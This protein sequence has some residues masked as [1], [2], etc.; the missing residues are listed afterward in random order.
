MKD[1]RN[2]PARRIAAAALLLAGCRETTPPLPAPGP[3]VDMVTIEI[4][5]VSTSGLALPGEARGDV[6]RALGYRDAAGENLV[7]FR[8]EAS[9]ADSDD[10]YVERVALSVSH[11]LAT[12][13]SGAG[14]YGE[15]W[16]TGETVDCEGLDFEADFL[17][18]ATR[19]EDLDGDGYA[20]IL[21]GYSTFCGGGLEPHDIRL[22]L[23][24]RERDYVLQGESLVQPPAGAPA[25]GGSHATTPAPEEIPAPLRDA[26]LDAWQRIRA[27]RA[28][29]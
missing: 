24:A 2:C 20:E 11:Y 10:G 14:G 5:E 21:V 12:G 22:V 1:D 25:F 8:R 13:G 29:G 27:F 6:R 23:H 3:P 19:I 7:V 15:R 4:Q 26:L 16:R 18:D 17:Q 28:P 9:G